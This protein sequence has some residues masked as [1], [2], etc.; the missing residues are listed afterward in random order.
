MEVEGR[1]AKKT[2]PMKRKT[3]GEKRSFIT[4]KEETK[5][6]MKLE[7]TLLLALI[8]IFVCRPWSSF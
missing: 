3:P 6:F 5:I 1:E 2:L 7:F 8:E 4:T